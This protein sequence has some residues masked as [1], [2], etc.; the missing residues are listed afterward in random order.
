MN[1]EGSAS[2]LPASAPRALIFASL[3]LERLR[4]CSI[5]VGRIYLGNPIQ[6]LLAEQESRLTAAYLHTPCASVA[7]SAPP[8][9]NARAPQRECSGRSLQDRQ[10]SPSWRSATPIALRKHVQSQQRWGESDKVHTKCYRA[11]S[12]DAKARQAPIFRAT[13]RQK[14]RPAARGNR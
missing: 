10:D 3:S 4:S 8:D 7:S 5:M 1:S 9:G 13:T 11:R 12:T 14:S 6:H 2:A